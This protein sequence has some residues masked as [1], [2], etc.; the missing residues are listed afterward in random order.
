MTLVITANL[1]FCLE[2]TKSKMQNIE[3]ISDSGSGIE[4]QSE[5]IRDMLNPA[6][7]ISKDD[8]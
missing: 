1:T 5:E 6:I 4:N 2:R 8:F 7:T 3:N